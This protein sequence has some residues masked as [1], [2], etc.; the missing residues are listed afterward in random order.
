MRLGVCWY[1]EQWPESDWADDVA[2]MADLG[3]RVVRIG[4]FAWAR[5]EPRRD[6]WDLGWLDRAVEAIAGAC[7]RVVLGTPTAT[8]PLWLLRER[9][10]IR[11]VGPDGR[12]RPTGSRRHTCPTSPAY[13]E[14]SA[15][16]AEVLAARY[17]THPAL[18]AWQVDNEPGNHDSAR[19]WCDAC[20]RAFRGWLAA[21]HGDVD[22]L[23]AAWGQAF[24]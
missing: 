8:P 2:R 16:V 3:L 20:Q 18:E 13:R 11:L 21:R 7:L 23:N 9:P 1:P 14:E 17:G 6:A 15:R 22:R 12:V 19:C 4:E 5:M 10:E 24:W